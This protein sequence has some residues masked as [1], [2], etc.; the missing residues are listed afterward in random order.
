[1]FVQ[2]F[3]SD[4]GFRLSMRLDRESFAWRTGVDLCSRRHTNEH[5]KWTTVRDFPPYRVDLAAVFSVRLSV[6]NTAFLK[7][8]VCANIFF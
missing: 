7:K 5:E 4:R 8:Y 1:M 6:K 3:F 2:I